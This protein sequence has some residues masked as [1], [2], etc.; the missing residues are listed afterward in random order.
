MSRDLNHVEKVSGG[1]KNTIICYS[2][3]LK[4]SQLVNLSFKLTDIICVIHGNFFFSLFS[5]NNVHI[6]SKLRFHGGLMAGEG[7]HLLYGRVAKR[8]K[9]DP[10]DLSTLQ[11]RSIYRIFSNMAFINTLTCKILQ[12]TVKILQRYLTHAVKFT[13]QDQLLSYSFH[14]GTTG[15]ETEF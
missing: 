7:R 5:F 12:S 2:D 10:A 3:K 15:G 13:L 6:F 9:H 11:A 14:T 1:R 4:L 8:M